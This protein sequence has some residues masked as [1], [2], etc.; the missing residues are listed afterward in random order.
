[1]S[2][3]PFD[4]PIKPA[5]AITVALCLAVVAYFVNARV[6]SSKVADSRDTPSFAPQ[7]GAKWSGGADWGNGSRINGRGYWSS[8]GWN[9]ENAPTRQQMDSSRWTYHP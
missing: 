1:M 6:A 8:N 2:T 4:K 9:Y 3:D 7:G 5:V